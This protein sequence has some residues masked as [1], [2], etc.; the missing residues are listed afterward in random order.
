MRQNRIIENRMRKKADMAEGLLTL[1]R[2]VI[3]SVIALVIL[4]VS[5]VF[6]DYY[7]DIRDSE[8][9]ILTRDVVNCLA[10]EG[11]FDFNFPA[12]KEKKVL[13]YCGIKNID[14][15]YVNITISD[16]SDVKILEQGDSGVL[17]IYEIFKNKE[18]V[19]NIAKYKIGYFNENYDIFVLKNNVKEKGKMQVEVLV[20]AE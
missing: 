15:F 2:I 17:W 16:E 7:L 5:A 11:V 9:M 19:K 20:N 14:R 6:Y 18:A 12:D 3:I 1:Y 10:P 8:A 13:D 4:G